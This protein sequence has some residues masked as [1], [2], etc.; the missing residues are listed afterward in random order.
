[1]FDIRFFAIDADFSES[2][3]RFSIAKQIREDLKE[4]GQ[5]TPLLATKSWW[6]Y[7]CRQGCINHFDTFKKNISI[8][9]DPMENKDE[10][11][12]IRLEKSD[13]QK[14]GIDLDSVRKIQTLLVEK[15]GLSFQSPPFALR[16]TEVLPYEEVRKL[17]LKD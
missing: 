5:N 12:L 9:V 15:S 7:D 10:S 14:L 8:V 4:H 17:I 13:F 6:Y 2:D 11:Q 1:M 3:A 16:A